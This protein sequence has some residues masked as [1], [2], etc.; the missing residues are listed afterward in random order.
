MTNKT[1]VKQNY[2]FR[3]WSLNPN[4]VTVEEDQ[5]QSL[6]S[7]GDILTAAA[8]FENIT[9]SN[10][11]DVYVFYAVFS[12]R[13]FTIHFKDPQNTNLEYTS[14]K[15]PYGSYLHEPVG[16][17]VTDESSLSDTER[18]KLV[19]WSRE[20]N[21]TNGNLYLDK[22]KARTVN[23]VNIVSQNED[24][25]FY[26]V[27]VKEDCLT[28]ATDDKY[29]TFTKYNGVVYEDES[30]SSY[31]VTTGGWYIRC[32]PGIVLKGKITLPA[33]HKDD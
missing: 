6:I 11:H 17:Y 15:A 9:F 4:Y 28:N 32:A 24:Q 23:L 12:I 18:Y 5:V 1:P 27:Y 31:N 13:T 26:G 20:I 7:S 30:D 16:Y 33:T 14:Y 8:D 25:T 19:G 21:A 22:T 3:G 29:F 10:E 2:V